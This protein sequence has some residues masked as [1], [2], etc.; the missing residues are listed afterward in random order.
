LQFPEGFKPTISCWSE[1]GSE[2]IS[3][4]VTNEPVRVQVNPFLV[5]RKDIPNTRMVEVLVYRG[6]IAFDEV[7]SEQGDQ[8]KTYRFVLELSADGRT[9]YKADHPYGEEFLV[10]VDLKA[11]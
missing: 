5:R 4:V 8:A 11:E 3:L 9:A 1:Q 10:P 6:E 2:D 7:P